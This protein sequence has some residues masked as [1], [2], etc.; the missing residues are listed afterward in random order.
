MA[1]FKDKKGNEWRIELDVLLIEEIEQDF[2][3]K[4]T[5][6]EH[7]PL[8]QLRNDPSVIAGVVC[9]LCKEQ[10]E[11]AGLSRN[12]FVKLL[13]Y[14]PDGM[15]DAVREA[16]IGFFPTGRASHVREVLARM[17][18]MAMKTDEIAAQKLAI[19]I[20]DPQIIAKLRSQCD[21]MF[22]QEIERIMPVSG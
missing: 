17:E 20:S 21:Q 15:L 5:D 14:P 22:N 18:E 12:E 13:P 16:I 1:K 11:A 3:I 8:L 6:I 2:K 19:V 10:R 4:L 7:D 9:L